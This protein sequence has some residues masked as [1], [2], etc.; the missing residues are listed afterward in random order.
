MLV[1]RGRFRA[2][3]AS[4][5][6]TQLVRTEEN[7]LRFYDIK[8]LVVNRD[9][10]TN[11]T[12]GARSEPERS[13]CHLP[14]VCGKLCIGYSCVLQCIRQVKYGFCERVAC[15]P[16]LVGATLKGTAAPRKYPPPITPCQHV[17]RSLFFFI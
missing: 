15:D 1:R 13:L 17:I 3:L 14:T 5:S 4:R 10:E 16:L 11:V 9:W 2:K 12:L 6:K 8:C 7:A